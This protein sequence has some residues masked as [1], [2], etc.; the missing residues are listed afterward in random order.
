MDPQ[1]LTLRPG[2]LHD[3]PL[4]PAMQMAMDQAIAEAVAAGDM[5]P[6]LR[7]WEWAAPAVIIGRFQSLD[8]EVDLDAAAREG[9]TVVRRVTGGGSMFVE[10]QN[11]I[12]Y[13]LYAPLGFVRGLDVRNSYR[14]CDQWLLGALRELGMRVGYQSINDIAS[15]QGKIGGAAQR[16]YPPRRGGPGAVLHHVTLA[17]DIDAVKMSRILIIS[18]EKMSDKAVR[19]A[20][21]RVDPMRRQTGLPRTRIIEHLER[22]LLRAIPGAVTAA[23]PARVIQRARQ[24][25]VNRFSQEKW[26]RSAIG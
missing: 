16:R 5:P 3:S 8:D 6:M 11:T 4:T 7:L 14:V 24:L 18:R 26:T 2:V 13:S 20:V 17:Y 21:K 12:T 10:P 19:S 22:Y 15:T 23:V 1:W 9:V 25:A